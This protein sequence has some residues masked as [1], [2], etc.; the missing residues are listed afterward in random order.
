[1]LPGYS[2]NGSQA[3]RRGGASLTQIT[4][5]ALFGL[6]SLATYVPTQ[7]WTEDDFSWGPGAMALA[8]VL[9]FVVHLV[10]VWRRTAP[11]DPAVWLPVGLM[12]FYF[13]TPIAVEGIGRGLDFTYD[14][15]QVGLAINLSRGYCGLLLALAAYLLGMHLAGIKDLSHLVAKPSADQSLALP[16]LILTL[17]S[18][19]MLAIGVAL[20]GPG[21]VFGTYE[22]WWGAKKAGADPRFV[23]MGIVF[24]QAGMFA[25]LASYHPKRR[26]RVYLAA[27]VALILAFVAIQ[28]G[29]RASLMATGVGIVW[30]YSQRVGRVHLWA[31]TLFVLVGV[32]TFPILGEY[33]MTKDLK[34]VQSRSLAESAAKGI[35]DM[36]A[37]A[38]TLF[39]TMDLVPAMESYAHGLGYAESL[40][41]L[42]PNVRLQAGRGSFTQDLKAFHSNWLTWQVAPVWAESGGGFGSSMAGELYF[43]FGVIGILLGSALVGWVSGRLRSAAGDSPMKLTASALFFGCMII[44]VRNPI[45]VP[46]KNLVWSLV[47]L[48]ILRGV[49]SLLTSRSTAAQVRPAAL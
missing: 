30:C 39:Y 18:L 40:Y 42:I 10:L 13:G 23:D 9:L 5:V 28:K 38:P 49:I 27:L 17:G 20:V 32:V 21:V 25:L 43:N 48:L 26:Y 44:Y 34:G 2:M 24:A 7:F 15:W 19:T 1:M 29:A 47:A 11:L 33:R 14:P 22:E 31:T 8:A 36:G 4:G 45:A 16:A 12:F 3:A 37:A 6:A 35:Y 46:L 41:Q